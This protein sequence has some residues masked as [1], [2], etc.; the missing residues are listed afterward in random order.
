MN[1]AT[2][3]LTRA[4]MGRTRVINTIQ[5]ENGY[6][7]LHDSY[8]QRIIVCHNID[9]V[10]VAIA[11]LVREFER[12]DKENMPAQELRKTGGALTVEMADRPE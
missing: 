4:M 2:G 11:D 12:H 3:M 9:E 10:N 5:A 6:I 1:Q 7:V 8:P